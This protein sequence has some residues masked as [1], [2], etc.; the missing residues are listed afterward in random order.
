MKHGLLVLASIGALCVPFVARADTITVR[1]AGAQFAPSG[2]MTVDPLNRTNGA[3]TIA[4]PPGTPAA[5]PTVH[6][7]D[8]ILFE[9]FEP[10]PHTVTKVSGPGSWTERLLAPL[11][12][13][14]L[15]ITSEFA[16]GSY[17]YRCMT[18]LGMRGSF[19]V[20]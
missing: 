13:A 15:A 4:L 10:F 8:T 3:G 17:V 14:D 11:G 12:T 1:V 6:R 18:H 9:N 19:T 20:A 5:G 16:S 7:G 2:Y